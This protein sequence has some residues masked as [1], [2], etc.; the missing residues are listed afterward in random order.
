[1]NPDI[2]AARD[3]IAAYLDA[4]AALPDERKDPGVPSR[5]TALAVPEDPRA[6]WELNTHDLRLVLAALDAQPA[7]IIQCDHVMTDQEFEDLKRRF[8]AAQHDGTPIRALDDPTPA[9]TDSATYMQHDEDELTTALRNEVYNLGVRLHAVTGE[10][11]HWAARTRKLLGEKSGR[12]T[13][14]TSDLSDPEDTP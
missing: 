3:R 4:F 10:R 12:L 14:E 8:L 2:R 1:V 5:I 11:D 13:P 7:A 9:I 6:C